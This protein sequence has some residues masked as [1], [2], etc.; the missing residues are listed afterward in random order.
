MDLPTYPLGTVDEGKRFVASVGRIRRYLVGMG[1][2][3][4]TQ[5][6]N[7]LLVPGWNI[8]STHRLEQKRSLGEQIRDIRSNK[9]D[10]KPMLVIIHDGGREPEKALVVT[11]LEDFAPMW[12]ASLDYG[13]EG[14]E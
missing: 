7:T 2:L 3:V 10:R 11:Y 14:T 12:L 1:L 5:S 13:S 8:R 9:P 4:Y 6:K